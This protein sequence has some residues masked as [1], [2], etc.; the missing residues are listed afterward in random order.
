DMSYFPGH[1]RYRRDRNDQHEY[2]REHVQKHALFGAAT[3]L[4][5]SH[6]VVSRTYDD[7]SDKWRAWR[8]RYDITFDDGSWLSDRKDSTPQPAFENLL[9]PREKQKESLQAQGVVLKKLRIIDRYPT[10]LIP[11]Y[12]RWT[13]PDGVS[14]NITSALSE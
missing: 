7:E 2:F 8:D 5:A 1:D 3:K 6:P 14:V 13:S 4:F 9:G 11:L 12:G 10:D